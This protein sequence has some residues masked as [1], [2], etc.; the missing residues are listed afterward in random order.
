MRNYTVKYDKN[1]IKQI[2]KM[3]KSVALLI[4]RWIEKNIVNT[5]NPRLHGKA[6]AGNLSNY[7]RYRIGD[8]RLICEINDNE[9]IIIALS[10]G[11]RREIYSKK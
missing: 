8:Y 3:D 7:C 6:L 4:K 9:L 5:D 10:V 1:F 2:Q 11:H